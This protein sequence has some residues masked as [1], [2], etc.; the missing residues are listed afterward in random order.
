[1]MAPV[2]LKMYGTMNPVTELHVLE[3]LNPATDLF[4]GV[5]KK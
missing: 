3:D 1:M 4:S 5:M 2:L